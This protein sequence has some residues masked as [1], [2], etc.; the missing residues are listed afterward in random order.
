M[1]RAV[2]ASLIIEGLESRLL[3]AA[4]FPTAYEQY[5]VEL[6]NRARANPVAE[7]ARFDTYE[8][9]R[10][11]VFSGD[12]NEGIP[13]GTISAAAKQPLA[14]NLFLTDSARSH[15]QWM[16]ANHTK[17]HVGLG[18]S[19]PAGRQ[20]S[21][22][23][24]GA[25]A[26]EENI[27]IE[28]SID[29][30]P[31]VTSIAEQHGNLFTDLILSGR[32]HRKNILNAAFKEVGVGIS[33]NTW[34]LP[35]GINN[36]QETTIDFG[37][38]S[39]TFLTG[40]AYA[41]KVTKDNFYTP[42]EGWSG[43]TV[44]A[45][46][47][48][49]GQVFSTTT[50][51]SGGYTLALSAGKYNIQASGGSLGSTVVYEGVT[52]GSENVKRDFVTGQASVL[53]IGKLVGS[54][55]VINGT[56]AADTISVAPKG[57]YLVATMNGNSQKFTAS[58]IAELAIK[59]GQGNDTITNA[60]V[61]GAYLEGGDGKD[62]LTGGSGNDSIYGDASNDYIDGGI[63]RDQLVGAGGA[64][65]ILGGSGNDRIYGG[66]GNDVLNGNSGS[67]RVLGGDGDDQIAGANG[68]DILAGEAGA[69]ILNGGAMRDTADTDSLDTR[70]AIEVLS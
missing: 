38:K 29:P 47:V 45:T 24:T 15:S 14:I 50:W 17:S 32:G 5:M 27:D 66:S 39:T 68:N 48:G 41:D 9:D 58:L 64:D 44:K 21:A 10:G 2:P 49:D 60:T 7:A 33:A 59:G 25:T 19:L 1:N 16:G 42:G 55:L 26:S 23:Y 31:A 4:V 13:P 51:A 57:S 12:L 56:S 34:N 52:V 28:F 37:A 54:T 22:G 36:S 18:G 46:R 65:L 20:A 35:N 62:H 40:V 8:D 6:I 43:V 63:G 70:I 67:D 53:T 11:V 69:D 3:R 61:L 30:I